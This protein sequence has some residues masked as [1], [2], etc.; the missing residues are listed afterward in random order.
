MLIWLLMLIS[1]SIWQTLFNWQHSSKFHWD[2]VMA[3]SSKVTEALQQEI[4]Q[5]KAKEMTLSAIAREAGHSKSVISRKLQVCNDTRKWGDIRPSRICALY[6][7]HPKCIQTAVNTHTVNTHPEQWA[8]IYAEGSVPC[9]RAPCRG[10][11]GGREPLYIH[12]PPPTIPAGPR[13]KPA[14]FRLRVWLSNH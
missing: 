14:T 5:M 3:G 11:E 4:V 1:L 8:A 6:L 9:S 10:I 12:S 13:I 2:C 7:S